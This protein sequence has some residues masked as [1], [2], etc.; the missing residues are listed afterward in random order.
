MPES[1]KKIY[2][3]T[4]LLSQPDKQ[5]FRS[6]DITQPVRILILNKIADELGSMLFQPGKH[7]VNVLHRE[8]HPQIAQCVYRGPPVI[9]DRTR[10][11]ESRDL[12]PAVAIRSDHHGDLDLLAG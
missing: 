12:Q 4:Q 11:E 2:S 5:S 6:P 7:L 1:Y 10:F 9:F 8:H 3:F